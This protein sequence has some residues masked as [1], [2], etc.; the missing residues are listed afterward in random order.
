[1]RKITDIDTYAALSRSS[2]AAEGQGRVEDRFGRREESNAS[3]AR[4]NF[5][6]SEYAPVGDPPSRNVT[7]VPNG[8][9]A[10]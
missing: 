6:P 2:G 7:G 8:V 10:H 5:R 9:P 1:M 3:V 4:T